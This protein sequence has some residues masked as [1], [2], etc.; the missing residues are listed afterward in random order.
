MSPPL[1]PSPLIPSC[2]FL[3]CYFGLLS[4]SGISHLHSYLG[5][6]AHAMPSSHSSF[7]FHSYV[8]PTL[9]LQGPAQEVFSSLEVS[10]GTQAFSSFPWAFVA[11]FPPWLWHLLYYMLVCGLT[12]S[13]LRQS[14]LE[15]QDC[16]GYIAIFLPDTTPQVLPSNLRL[17]IVLI[18]TDLHSL[19]P[20]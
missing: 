2:V 16:T 19:L 7:P 18:R 8:K 5:T 3:F 4:T 6:F 12:V 11:L 20:A 17:R 13:F 9:V 10:P 15:F 1:A 14:A